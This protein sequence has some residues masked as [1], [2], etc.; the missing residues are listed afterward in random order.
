MEPATTRAPSPAE[1]D[2]LAQAVAA[3]LDAGDEARA[4]ALT[5]WLEAAAGLRPDDRQPPSPVIGR[6]FARAHRDLLVRGRVTPAAGSS[7]AERAGTMAACTHGDD[8]G[9][10]SLPPG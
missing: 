9:S 10:G 6:R 3:A 5:R 1:L 8:V 2:A 4:W 7:N